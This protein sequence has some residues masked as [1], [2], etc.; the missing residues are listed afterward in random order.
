MD[1][2]LERRLGRRMAGNIKIIYDISVLGYAHFVQHSRTGVYRVVEHTALGLVQSEE[3]ETVFCASQ[4]NYLQC[5]EYLRSTEL[6]S[7]YIKI[8][9]Q[10]KFL[11]IISNLFN[12][13][14]FGSKKNTIYNLTDIL[15]SKI[16]PNKIVYTDKPADHLKKNDIYHSPFYPIPSDTNYTK[17][18]VF[19][20]VYDLIG[21]LFPN[22]FQFKKDTLLCRIMD[23]IKPD[24]FVLCIS[25]ATKNDLLNYSKIV[26]K[27]KV[28]VVPLAASD[29]FY[30]CTDRAKIAS[31]R[32]KYN[33]PPNS[34]YVLSVSTLE[35]RKNIDLTIK[36]FVRI[37]QEENINDLYL[38][39]TG[40]KGWD[41]GK[42][43]SEIKNSPAYKD[44]IILTNYVPDEDLAPLY[45]GALA[46]V[47][48]SFYEGFGL[49]P[50]EAM[51]CGTPVITSNT[52]SLPEVVGDAGIMID[53]TD[54]DALCQAML[55][56]YLKP[57]IQKNMSIKSLA[58]ARHFSWRNNFQGVINAYKTAL[59]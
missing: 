1:Q 17:I 42:I 44:K 21:I 13:I 57:D 19:Q 55:Y 33:I 39:L 25:E 48:P 3:C 47:Y 58:R 56:V 59:G 6:M 50:L 45:T 34:L 11:P 22:Y 49:P 54:L 20:T 7:D 27:N 23:S 31:V 15:L 26:D 14:P 4:G 36:A 53:P 29:N 12:Y 40:T 18:K 5:M 43:F 51:Q 9:P 8:Y 32:N 16:L 41:Y 37:L 2:S 46:F 35:P 52:S 30:H 38:V 10:Y 28:F 24:T